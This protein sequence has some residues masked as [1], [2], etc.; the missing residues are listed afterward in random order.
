MPAPSL[1]ETSEPVVAPSQ[2]ATPA[3]QSPARWR[4]HSLR[5]LAMGPL[6]IVALLAVL[7]VLARIPWLQFVGFG[8]V[9]AASG[10]VAR[11][12]RLRN[13]ALGLQ[14]FSHL[15]VLAA[16]ALPWL[17]A[18]LLIRRL[19]ADSYLI[20]PSSA[21]RRLALYGG[22]FTIALIATHLIV[23][24]LRGAAPRNFY[25][26]RQSLK[27]LIARLRDRSLARVVFNRVAAASATFHLPLLAWLGGFCFVS[28]W[29]WL[30]LPAW[31][32]SHGTMHPEQAWVGGILLAAIAFVLP[33]IQ[34]RFAA[35]PHWTTVFDLSGAWRSFARA[36]LRWTLA[37]S[38][39][40]LL[41][42]P[43]YALKLYRFPVG[44]L[45]M[46]S[47]IVVAVTF[48]IRLVTGWALAGS[49][50]GQRPRSPWIV[51]PCRAVLLIV[52]TTYAVIVYY[53]QYFEWS[54]AAG[55][56]KQHAFLLPNVF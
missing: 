37:G 27:W 13:G 34:A 29:L 52:A 15:V 56:W 14:E 2:A 9:L 20:D 23:G 32:L 11:S 12:G 3:Q 19:V 40:L 30:A 16:T 28:S 50:P 21:A 36:P 18:G 46:A 31:L 54:G 22:W 4:N 39:A 17:T 51:W 49:D 35:I 33:I 41:P 1:S 42:L 24:L 55:L 25:Q 43:L 38:I 7:A 53:M 45:W 26:P 48:L 8:Y 44:L 47:G 5:Y 10:H 6:G